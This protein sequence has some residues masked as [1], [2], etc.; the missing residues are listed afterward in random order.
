MP[1]NDVDGISAAD[2]LWRL[3]PVLLLTCVALTILVLNTH[4]HCGFF[5][6]GANPDGPPVPC[7]MPGAIAPG[8]TDSM[9]FNICSICPTKTSHIP[10]CSARRVF[11]LVRNA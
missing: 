7:I 11:D 6:G 8:P 3:L 5:S 10:Y 2:G 1:C 4:V 9:C